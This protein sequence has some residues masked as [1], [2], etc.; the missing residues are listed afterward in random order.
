VS[1]R[2]GIETT[3]GVGD[4]VANELVEL[5]ESCTQ[6]NDPSQLNDRADARSIKRM[7][8]RF[9]PSIV[10]Q[11]IHQLYNPCSIEVINIG[12][13]VFGLRPSDSFA[14]DWGP[15]PEGGKDAEYVVMGAELLGTFDYLACHHDCEPPRPLLQDTLDKA[16]PEY[17]NTWED[18]EMTMN[19]DEWMV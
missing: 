14:L 4:H 2:V 16:S 1:C 10:H 5:E 8:S 19:T 6:L 18:E 3:V 12:S 9:P 15:E 11:G 13:V 7:L 17:P